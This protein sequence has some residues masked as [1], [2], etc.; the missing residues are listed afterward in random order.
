MKRAG[1]SKTVCMAALFCA[2]SVVASHAQTFTSLVHFKGTNGMDPAAALIQ[3][4][5]GNF[6]GT[7]N[8]GG[9]NNSACDGQTC[10]TLFRM[11]PAGKVTTL[12]MFCSLADC[13]D[14]A[15]PG[16]IVLGPDGNIYGVTATGGSNCHDLAIIGCGTIFKFSPSG[17]LTTLYSVCAQ[18]NCLDGWNP[19]SLVLGM[20]G[21]FYGTTFSG[22]MTTGEGLGT[23]FRI[24]PTGSF[25]KIRSFCTE[26]G[27]S[28]LD[29]GLPENLVQANGNFY[30]TT[31][32]GGTDSNSC[33]IAFEVKPTGKLTT[34]HSFNVAQGCFFHSPLIQATD[35]NLY[36]TNSN[37]G[38]PHRIGIAYQLTP[39]GGFTR[40]YSFCSLTDCADGEFPEAG[41]VQA[42]DGNFYGATRGSLSRPV[43]DGTIFEITSEGNLTTLYSFNSV[44]KAA[45]GAFPIASLLQATDGNFYGTTTSGGSGYGTAFKVSTGLAPFVAA[46]PSFG[47]IGHGVMIL[48]NNLTGTTSVTFNGVSAE[49][50][51]VSSTFL[52][53]TVPTGATT[54]TIEVTTPSGTLNSN[55]AFQ[56]LP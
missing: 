38:G 23:F 53:A 3:G 52:R 47:K 16:Q 31:Y 33:G 40:L 43:N 4:P 39:A 49:F 10:G 37:G 22:G 1:F 11:T 2:V 7:T 29:G 27:T 42:T 25:T 18:T 54:G 56:V 34:L 19:D 48:G 45:E 9:L 32:E 20:D 12:Y 41:L 24:T 6:Y 15:G 21:N 50:Q 35:G 26:G 44:P 46:N 51:V 30:G 28:C 36:G 14:G 5:D 8:Q 13:N 55:I 17:T